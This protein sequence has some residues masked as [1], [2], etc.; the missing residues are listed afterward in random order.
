MLGRRECEAHRRAAG[1]GADRAAT[2]E[3]HQ[4]SAIVAGRRRGSL[5]CTFDPASGTLQ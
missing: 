3:G 5:G 2:E 4:R 1:S